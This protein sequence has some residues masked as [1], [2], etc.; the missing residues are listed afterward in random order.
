MLT[1]HYTTRDKEGPADLAWRSLI[2]CQRTGCPLPAGTV[3]AGAGGHRSCY[4]ESSQGLACCRAFWD[5]LIME[6]CS[7]LVQA[8]NP[9]ISGSHK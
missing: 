4:P 3:Q 2:P 9:L 1:N 6:F 8:H 7:T 5:D